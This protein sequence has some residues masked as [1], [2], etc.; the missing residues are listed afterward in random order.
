MLQK[1]STVCSSWNAFSILPNMDIKVTPWTSFP[2]SPP[3]LTESCPV[4][5]TCTQLKWFPW[6]YLDK[7][8]LNCTLRAAL[9]CVVTQRPGVCKGLVDLPTVTQTSI[10]ERSGQRTAL[11]D[12]RLSV[13]FVELG[14]DLT[15]VLSVL[16]VSGIFHTA[17]RSRQS[18]FL[19]VGRVRAQHA[20][21]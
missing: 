1:G 17:A 4:S 6:G 21:C 8:G 16:Q 20:S 14:S 19:E 10:P 7:M 2:I 3:S 15:N 9:G 12:A 18:M 13:L 5:M 11:T